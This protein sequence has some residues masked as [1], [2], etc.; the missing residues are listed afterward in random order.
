MFE[1]FAWGKTRNEVERKE[2]VE[3]GFFLLIFVVKTISLKSLI[4]IPFSINFC[5][6]YVAKNEIPECRSTASIC[7]GLLPTTAST[8]KL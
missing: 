4:S 5:F 7:K 8:K 1:K 2:I 3:S 6:N